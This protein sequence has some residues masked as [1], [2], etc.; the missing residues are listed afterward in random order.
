VAGVRSICCNPIIDGLHD[1]IKVPLHLTVGKPQ[2]ANAQ[3]L[4]TPLPLV[5]FN[6]LQLV[7]VSVD[8]HGQ[9]QISR[10]EIHDVP[11]NGLLPVKIKSTALS[12]FEMLPKQDLGQRAMISQVTRE[13]F[14]ARV[15]PQFHQVSFVKLCSLR[16]NTPRPSATPLDRG[17]LPQRR[18][19][20]PL[21]RGARRAGC[22][23]LTARS[24]VRA[25]P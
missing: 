2:K 17:E 18:I 21:E 6:S 16:K 4:Y 10:K 15:V 1:C 8:F 23:A 3:G 12:A 13:P 14:K 11:V 9:H 22:V 25:L 20:S 19:W 24:G 5:I 7:T